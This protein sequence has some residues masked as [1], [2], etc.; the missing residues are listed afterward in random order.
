M[1]T[2]VLFEICSVACCAY[3]HPLIRSHLFTKASVV[4][5][6][7]REWLCVPDAWEVRL[8][9]S[10][11]IKIKKGIQ[12]QTIWGSSSNKPTAWNFLGKKNSPTSGS[13]EL[14]IEIMRIYDV[15]DIPISL[16]WY[17][18]RRSAGPVRG[19]CTVIICPRER[20][21]GAPSELRKSS[22]DVTEEA[23]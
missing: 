3:L 22:S 6:M 8:L 21:F 19:G 23:V 14:N 10:K 1:C 11:M 5:Q 12:R 18:L 2:R 13:Y 7:L 9:A 20:L 4:V 16:K 15:Y 17:Q